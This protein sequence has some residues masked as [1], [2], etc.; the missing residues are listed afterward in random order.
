[1]ASFRDRPI[2]YKV[3]LLIAV[4]SIVGM[5]FAGVVVVVYDLVTFRPRVVRDLESQ[6][7]IIGLNTIPALT[8]GDPKAASENLA[9]LQSRPE[10]G[11]ASIRLPSGLLFAS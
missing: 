8:F 7:E 10:I 2:R 6:A 4:A 3:A 9:T 1:M 5:G 11:F